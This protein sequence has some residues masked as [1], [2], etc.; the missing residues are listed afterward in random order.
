MHGDIEVREALRWIADILDWSQIP[1]IVLGD[2][3]P[4]M[5]N[6]EPISVAKIEI[7]IQKNAWNDVTK[8]LVNT[9]LLATPF[10]GMSLEEPVGF[11]WS[12]VPIELKIIKRNYE[13][14]K[15]P[16]FVYYWVD[17]YKIPN[18]WTKYYKSRYLIK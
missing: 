7:G 13:F 11:E 2:L 14:F 15:N 6:Q 3:V 4:Q 9:F 8:S 18:P 12:G 10:K 5:I 1:Y 17:E 16:D